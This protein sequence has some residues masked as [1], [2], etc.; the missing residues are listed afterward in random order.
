MGLY[1]ED[2][3]ICVLLNIGPGIPADRD[4]QE[5]DA[6]SLSPISRLA[7]RI[8]WSSSRGSV[9][10]QVLM[11]TGAGDP[12]LAEKESALIS[13]SAM[14]LKLEC[15]RREDLRDRLERLYGSSGGEIYHHLGPAYSAELASLNDVNALGQSRHESADLRKQAE[16][17]AQDM[18]RRVW[19]NAA[20]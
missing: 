15:W 7:R 3:E 8:S 1:G 12:E 9:L 16:A 10:R 19:V 20:S 4:C 6:M 18:V 11:S 2:V 5:L 13:P 14:A 17:E